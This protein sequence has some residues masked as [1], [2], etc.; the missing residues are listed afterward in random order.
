MIKPTIDIILISIASPLLLG[1]YKNQKLIQ[2]ISKTGKLSDELPPIFEQ[3]L[4]E[5]N[6]QNIIYTHSPGN[7]LGIKMTYIFLKTLACC[8]E[9][10]RLK[11]IDGF[12]FNNNQPIK[13]ILG[14]YFI[15]RDSTIEMANIEDMQTIENSETNFEL[16]NALSLKDF[17]SEIEPIYIAPAVY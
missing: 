15:K 9:H 1:I 10:I 13:A 16:P 12:Y 17:S 8:N 6:I 3:L 11:A 4:S 5:Y 7:F 14:Q 2:K